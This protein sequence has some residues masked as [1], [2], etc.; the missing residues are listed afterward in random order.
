MK[1][2]ALV[3]G[4]IA[5]SSSCATIARQ[6][7]AV[8]K[9]AQGMTRQ[10]VLALLGSPRGKE[11]E[12]GGKEIWSYYFLDAYRNSLTIEAAFLQDSLVRYSF[13]EGKGTDDFSNQRMPRILTAQP[14]QTPTPRPAPPVSRQERRLNEEEQDFNDF[15]RQLREEAFP[16]EQLALLRQTSLRCTY[17]VKQAI[18]IL[19]VFDLE[20]E[21]L[22][23]LRIIAPRLRRGY[24]I[25]RLLEFFDEGM[26]RDEA[27]KI[28]ER[29]STPSSSSEW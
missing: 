22:D 10:Q 29:R 1:V 9:M 27:R 18:Q 12:A 16:E 21:Q 26:E 7:T 6:R 4:V 19:G 23:A 3:V 11:V 2:L 15:L 13:F 8:H 14:G 5:L 28:L 17:S 25:G 24:N 20:E